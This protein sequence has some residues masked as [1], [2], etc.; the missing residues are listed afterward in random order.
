MKVN[1]TQKQVEAIK[2]LIDY[3]IDDE[4]EHLEEMISDKLDI[5]V[6]DLTDDDLFETYK[7]DTDFNNHIWFSIYELQ[8]IIEK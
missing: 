7:D 6:S 5:E 1:L 8:K 4:R 2:K 3:T